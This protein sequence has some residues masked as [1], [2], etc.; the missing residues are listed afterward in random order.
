LGKRAG[1]ADDYAKRVSV[2]REKIPGDL[3]RE[4]GMG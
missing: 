4:A 3:S 2:V 1:S